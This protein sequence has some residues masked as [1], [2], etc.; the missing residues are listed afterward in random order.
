[1]IPLAVSTVFNKWPPSG[2]VCWLILFLKN[3]APNGFSISRW[4]SASV[5]LSGL[6]L[7]EKQLLK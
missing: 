4:S 2:S 6:P 5:P 7:V 1:M 3:R